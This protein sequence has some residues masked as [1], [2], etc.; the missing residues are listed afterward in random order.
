MTDGV[1]WTGRA[2]HVEATKPLTAFVANPNLDDQLLRHH[3]AAYGWA[4]ACCRWEPALAEDV[5]QTAYLKLLDGR[6]RHGGTADFQAF[7]FGVIRRTALEERRRRTV[8]RVLSLGLAGSE[9]ESV[10]GNGLEPIIRDETSRALLGALDRLSS[11]QRE[12]LHLVFYQ[13]LTI[14]AA[15]G[16]LGISVGSAR[17]HYERGKAQ[18]R[19][20][21]GTE[22]S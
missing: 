15:A 6:A 5:L 9:R 20:L 3:R 22:S 17:V 12:V 7:L 16:V 19:T 21:L 8:R 4:L 2:R 1:I 13:D 18:L 10:N 14:A 11:R